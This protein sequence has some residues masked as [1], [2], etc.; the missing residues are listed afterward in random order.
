VAHELNTPIGN[1]RTVASALC[2]Q[3]QEFGEKVAAVGIRKSELADFLQRVDDGTRLLDS[4]LARATSLIQ[5]FKQ[6]AV[7]RASSQR[8]RFD[9]R[10]VTEEVIATLHPALMMTPYVV[11]LTLEPEIRVDGYPGPYG[12]VIV[13]LIENALIHG[14]HDRTQGTIRVSGRQVGELAVIEVSDNGW[15]IAAENLPHVFDPFFTTRLGRGGSGL[16]L[17][18]A[19]NIVTG[20]LGGKITVDSAPGAGACFSIAMPLHAPERPDEAMAGDD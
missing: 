7:D 15:G 14:L 6:V 4:N 20:L 8:R 5:S 18:I 10:G 9:L 13:S 19:F 3:S 1:A 2:D 12:Q 16:G 17:N 11:D